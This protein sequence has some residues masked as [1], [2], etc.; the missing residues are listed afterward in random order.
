MSLRILGAISVLHQFPQ[1][2]ATY[3]AQSLSD[4]SII[5]TCTV[6]IVVFIYCSVEMTG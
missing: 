5:A 2:L 3:G 4:G 1:G 6:A